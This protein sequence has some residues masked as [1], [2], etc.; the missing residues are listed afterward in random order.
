MFD[1]KDVD[2]AKLNNIIIK[3]IGSDQKS[4]L[5]LNPLIV[6][7]YFNIREFS[8]Y[9]ISSYVN[10]V[11]Y[12][13]N[14]I[15]L[16]YQSKIGLN[17]TYLNYESAIENTQKSLNELNSVIYNLPSSKESYNKFDESI[18]ILHSLLNKHIE[19]MALLFKNENKVKDI[20]I[21]SMP[22]NFYDSYFKISSNNTKTAGYISTFDMY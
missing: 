7:F 4:Y 17:R 22:D 13:N 9:N 21:N 12:A 8:Q 15:G 20:S 19:E 1:N 2:Y 16:S 6:E 18:R 11:I 14:V 10:S 3:P 5:Y